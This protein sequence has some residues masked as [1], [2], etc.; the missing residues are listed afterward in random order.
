MSFFEARVPPP[1]SASRD[2]ANVIQ[3]ASPP[4]LPEPSFESG[5]DFSPWQVVHIALFFEVLRQLSLLNTHA[6]RP[7]TSIVFP[8]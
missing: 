1:F 3:V 4:L 5:S 8:Q 2:L 6:D 7:S